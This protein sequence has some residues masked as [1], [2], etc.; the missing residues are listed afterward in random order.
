MFIK[1]SSLCLQAFQDD[2]SKVTSS[3]GDVVGHLL[4][5]GGMFF[6]DGSPQY[7]HNVSLKKGFICF[8]YLCT[9]YQFFKPHIGGQKCD[10][11]LLNNTGPQVHWGRTRYLAGPG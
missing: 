3:G 10:T 11:V 9:P 1:H 8:I 7:C 5:R 4:C 2:C 6:M